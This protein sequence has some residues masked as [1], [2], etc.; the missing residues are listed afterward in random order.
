[1]ISQ[2]NSKKEVCKRKKQQI[3]YLCRTFQKNE[4]VVFDLSKY[5]ISY[6]NSF[7]VFK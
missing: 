4:L 7:F 3:Y 6:Q 2:K 1:M 5:I